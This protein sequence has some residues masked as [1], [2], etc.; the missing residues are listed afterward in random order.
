MKAFLQKAFVS[1]LFVLVSFNSYAETTS[2]K[3]TIMT[4]VYPPFNMEI[5]GKLTGISVDVLDAMLELLNTGQTRED[6]I[7]SNWSRA[8]TMAEKRKNHMVFSTTR[9]SQRE[10]LFK[11]VGPVSKITIGIIAPKEKGIVINK[12]SDLNQYRIGTVLKDI[13]EQTLLEGGILKKQIH[14]ISGKNSID[15]SFKKMENDRIDLFAYATKGAMYEA[16]VKGHDVNDFEVIYTVKEGDLY[17]AFNK[18]T[19][20]EIITQWQN[21]L[22]AVKANGLYDEIV[23]RY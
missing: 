15:L 22:D 12:F 17:Y 19:S 10:S 21:A 18:E 5:D 6:I 14:S 11:W 7:L 13:G 23:K 3:I 16:K 8:Y 2:Q 1:L 4:E 9:T 20:D